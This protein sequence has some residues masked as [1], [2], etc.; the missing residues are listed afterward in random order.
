MDNK[1][2][3][4]KE[5]DLL[6]ENTARESV[7]KH[8]KEVYG[9]KM[10]FSTRISNSHDIQARFP[11]QYFL[12]LNPERGTN[13]LQNGDFMVNWELDFDARSFCV[14]EINV[15]VTGVQG[16]FNFETFPVGSVDFENPIQTQR[17]FQLPSDWNVTSNIDFNIKPIQPQEL[18]FDFAK[19]S[20]HVQ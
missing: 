1:K 6:I 2:I 5:L 15:I 7:S 3:K 18:K 14:K 10:S 19:R 13:T 17:T 4:K 16:Y 12:D 8:L 20:I 11:E 9:S